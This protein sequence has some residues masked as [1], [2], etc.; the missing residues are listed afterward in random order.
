MPLVGY[1]PTIPAFEWAKI[2]YAL[3]R[4]ASVNGNVYTSTE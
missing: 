3:D 1:E 4:S 2:L